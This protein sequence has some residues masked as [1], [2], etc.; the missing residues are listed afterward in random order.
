[1]RRLWVL[2]RRYGFDALV[3]VLAVAAMI[4]V[5]IR[6]TALGA[7]QE[8]LWLRVAAMG[9]IVLPLFARRRFPFGAPIAY[10]LLAVAVSF[11]DGRLIPLTTGI[12]ILTMVV[13]FLL[14]SAPNIR[15]ARLGLVVVVVG[16]A[17]VVYNLTTHSAIQLVYIP[18]LFGVCWF[19]GFAVRQRGDQAAA[20][21]E[22]A[23]RAERDRQVSARIA[24]AEERA[25][26]ARELHDIVAHAVSVMVL[27]TGAV[28]H[29]LPDDFPDEKEAL[30]G[31]EE[32]GRRA[33][34]EMRH[35]LGALRRD[36]EAAVLSPQPGMAGL[37]RLLEEVREAGLPVRLEVLGEPV[38]LPGPI[39]LAVYRIAQE[40]LTNVLKHARAS[41]AD[42]S[43]HYTPGVL[44]VDVRDD[45]DGPQP[46]DGLGHGLVG[47][48]ERVKIYGG[49]LAAG[50]RPEGGFVLSARLPLDP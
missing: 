39:D 25:R 5:V 21:E 16:A 20:A 7:P 22:R 42:V 13:A 36:D 23:T 34:S 30:R 10:W 24:V 27:Q 31:V 50:P 45:G 29:R 4:E 43:L 33:L 44:Q 2:A 3:V 32:T 17:I 1:V 37:A 8:T 15:Q 38:P 6:H 35:L 40:G 12:F 18:L 19:L 11:I 48:R 9:L 41:H 46:G 28:R 47:M 26:I 14:G 49:E